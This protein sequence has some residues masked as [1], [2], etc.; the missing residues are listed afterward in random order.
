MSSVASDSLI[1]PVSTVSVPAEQP[2]QRILLNEQRERAER[3]LNGVRALVLLLLGAAALAYAPALPPRLNAANLIVLAPMLFWTIGQ[4]LLFYRSGPLPEWLTVAN[5]IADITAITAILFGYGLTESA[6]LALKSPLILAYFVVLAAR[7]IASSARKAGFVA[8]LAVFEY[9]AL[10]SF[11]LFTGRV[12]TLN[13]IDA[14][15]GGGVSILDECAKLL[16]LAVAGAIATYAT[17]W[18]ER[19]AKSYFEQ[20]R[21]RED[22]QARLSEA[23]LETL[24]LQLHPHFLFNTLNTIT[25]LISTAPRSAEVMVTRLSELLRAT[26]RNTGYGEQDGARNSSRSGQEVPLSQELEILQHYIG[27]QQERFQDRLKVRMEISPDTHTALVPN[28][29]LQPLVEN[30]I[31]HG[32]SPRS[33]PGTVVVHA[34]RDNGSL[35]LRVQD[36]GI[37]SDGDMQDGVGIGNARARLRHLYG[38]DHDF[39]IENLEK[40]FSVMLRIPFR[41]GQLH[42]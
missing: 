39:K 7:P 9:G 11:F 13:P 3:L 12:A 26:L 8:A 32:I 34:E 28:L 2:L 40:G 25:A 29:I 23:Q 19:M 38:N 18:H 24:K 36:D 4:Y 30:A 10:T 22:L 14:S 20:A 27:I 37:G 1:N 41:T 6:V 21:E 35:V 15:S 33:A 5:P 42:G 16:L 31:K 17:A